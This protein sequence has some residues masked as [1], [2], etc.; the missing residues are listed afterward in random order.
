M[1][2][3]SPVE[4]QDGHYAIEMLND[5]TDK[6][7]LESIVVEIKKTLPVSFSNLMMLWS[8]MN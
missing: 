1:I 7:I 3:A 2:T 5:I 4:H 8:E 6:S